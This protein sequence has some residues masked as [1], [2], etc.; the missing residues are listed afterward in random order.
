LSVLPAGAAFLNYTTLTEWQAVATQ[1]GSTIDFNSLNVPV[2]GYSVS[3]QSLLIDDVTFTSPTA[4]W[5]QVVNP[6]GGQPW[7]YWGTTSI[8]RPLIETPTPLKAEW[9]TGVTA[10]AALMAINKEN[11]P[12][13]WV[14]SQ[15]DVKVR[16]GGTVVWEQTL[17]T[18]AHPTPTFFG[19]VSTNPAETFDSVTFTPAEVN[20]A[21]LDDVRLGAYQDPDPVPEMGTGVLSLCGGI[22]LVAG[23]LRKRLKPS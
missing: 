18:S 5:M 21:F 8:L 17:V 4:G 15:M 12:G 2:G 10:F 20:Y 1:A 19:F 6:S 7:Y 13:T 3:Y 9:A 14:S 11:P 23:G 22:L 16:S